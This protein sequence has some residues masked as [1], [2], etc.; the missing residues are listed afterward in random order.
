MAST[1]EAVYT[2]PANGR[3]GDQDAVCFPTTCRE[4]QQ[5]LIIA[6]KQLRCPSGRSLD[7]S[8]AAP[9]VYRRGMIVPC[10]DE[11]A[12]C[13]TLDCEGRSCTAP[14]GSCFAGRCYCRLGWM[15]ADCS[16]SLVTG[17][18]STASTG[19]GDTST[20]PADANWAAP[21]P[22][23]C[24]VTTYFQL[25]Q[26]ACALNQT[27]SAFYAAASSFKSVLGAWADVN[28][29]Q[30]SVASATSNA[31]SSGANT[32]QQPAALQQSAGNEQPT[33]TTTH[34]VVRQTL[35]GAIEAAAGRHLAALQPKAAAPIAQA[36]RTRNSAGGEVQPC[37]LGRGCQPGS[38]R[39]AGATAPPPSTAAAAG[40][41]ALQV[42]VSLRPASSL[43][44]DLVMA[45]LGDP[46]QVNWLSTQ[47]QAAGFLLIPVSCQH[48]SN[49]YT[50]VPN[51]TQV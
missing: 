3:E 19:S 16:L 17:T 23:F 30:L 18:R 26:I 20:P 12:T 43:Q 37:S 35:W 34:T 22:A 46:S 38:R 44:A 5:Y 41:G 47:L 27:S 10:P 11:A 42:M 33:V 50:S 2:F 8:Q 31:T 7:L 25:I 36:Q 48:T 51:P 45:K 6:G 32:T 49:S 1:N 28:A 15:G 29:A 13:A 24:N 39:L 9:D 40:A 14:G 21:P 4:G